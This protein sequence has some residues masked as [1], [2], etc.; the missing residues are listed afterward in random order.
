VNVIL[1]AA[2]E[3]EMLRSER[4][5]YWCRRIGIPDDM[6]AVLE[7][8][9][10]TILADDALAAAMEE[11][12]HRLVVRHEW[13]EDWTSPEPEPYGTAKLGE[14]AWAVDFLAYLSVLPFAEAWY[15]NKRIS[16]HVFDTTMSDIGLWVRNDH[17]KHGTW[18]FSQF[19]WIKLHLSCQL[20]RL[21]RLQF[22]L[23]DYPSDMLFF[24]RKG[25][26]RESQ[27]QEGQDRHVGLALPENRLRADGY[28]DG[29]DSRTDPEFW[30]PV[31]EENAA[32]WT[33]NPTSP[34]G[35][36]AREKVFLPREEWE[37]V[38]KK[39]DKVIDIHIPQG[40]KLDMAECRESFSL[41]ETFFSRYFPESPT[42]VF[43]CDTW[44]FAP[45]LQTIL[46]G[47]GN[48]VKFQREFYLTP[49]AGDRS[50]AWE[51]IFGNH[52]DSLEKAPR[53]STIQI[54][55]HEWLTRGNEVFG[56]PGV[57]FHPAAVWGSQPYMRDRD[58]FPGGPEVSASTSSLPR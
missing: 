58:E 56:L 38:L 28:A 31:F 11:Y 47:K 18:R 37:I 27:D 54:A 53:Q 32:G 13:G 35:W 30:H 1:P 10:K 42:H 5:A 16:M 14:Y 26:D 46:G 33:G 34:Y 15:Q 12:H 40:G 25:Q 3:I 50:Q 45:Q 49:E 2:G 41:A 17:E 20:F 55:F 51:R 52:V 9:R 36:V 21:G 19:G 4:L 44:L 43:F 22:R 8:I 6:A 7:P 57:R 29:S 39:G 48:I 23:L 24:R